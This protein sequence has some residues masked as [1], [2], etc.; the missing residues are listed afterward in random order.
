VNTG[1]FPSVHR[2]LTL[3]FD[4]VAFASL[5]PSYNTQTHVPLKKKKKG[6][7]TTAL[8]NKTKQNKNNNTHIKR[9]TCITRSAV[10]A[11]LGRGASSKGLKVYGGKKTKGKQK[12]KK[13]EKHG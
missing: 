9:T 12:T 11:N 6:N 5:P 4:D 2:W 7:P 8:K 13:V 1:E 3:S 10:P